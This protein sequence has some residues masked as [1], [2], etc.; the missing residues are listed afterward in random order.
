MAKH[1]QVLRSLTNQP[2]SCLTAYVISVGG[3]TPFC[4]P[5]C[6]FL[7]Q[8]ITKYVYEL[9]QKEC[10]LK[11][12]TLPVS[13]ISFFSKDVVCLDLSGASPAI[14]TRCAGLCLRTPLHARHDSTSCLTCL[15]SAAEPS[16]LYRITRI[17]KI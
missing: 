17:F 13:V 12:V 4:I 7:F 6:L 15:I 8:I 5:F 16:L 1:I 9:L 14:K 2:L 11:K 3:L 10:H